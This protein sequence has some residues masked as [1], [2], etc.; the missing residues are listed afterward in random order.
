MLSLDARPKEKVTTDAVVY[1]WLCAR[2]TTKSRMLKQNDVD[3]GNHN[4]EHDDREKSEH[5]ICRLIL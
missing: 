3:D 1:V 5:G 2:L 4:R